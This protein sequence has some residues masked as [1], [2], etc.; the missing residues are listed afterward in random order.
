LRLHRTKDPLA[1][2]GLWVSSG[3]WRHGFRQWRNG[4]PSA[5][6]WTCWTVGRF[7]APVQNVDACLL[8]LRCRAEA[9]DPCPPADFQTAEAQRHRGLSPAPSAASRAVSLQTP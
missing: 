5:G 7:A 2:T 9:H 1:P 3:G 8:R 6:R 4:L